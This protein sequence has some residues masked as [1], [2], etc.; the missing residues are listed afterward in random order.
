MRRHYCWKTCLLTL[1]IANQQVDVG[2]STPTSPTSDAAAS[3]NESA[4]SVKTKRRG[5]HKERRGRDNHDHNNKAVERH[6]G[7]D[8]QQ[9]E[10][11][12]QGK[13]NWK[14]WVRQLLLQEHIERFVLLDGLLTRAWR[15]NGSPNRRKSRATVLAYLEND[16]RRVVSFALEPAV[17]DK[18][19]GMM[20]PLHRDEA[21]LMNKLFEGMILQVDYNTGGDGFYQNFQEKLEIPICR[22]LET[23]SSALYAIDTYQLLEPL[24]LQLGLTSK[25][26][27]DF[28]YTPVEFSGVSRKHHYHRGYSSP[29]ALVDKRAQ[30]TGP[31]WGRPAWWKWW[32]P[33]GNRNSFWKGPDDEYKMSESAFAGGSHGEVWRGRRLCRDE[34]ARRREPFQET[35]GESQSLIF[36]RLKVEHGYRLFEAGLREVYIGKLLAEDP[37]AAGLFTTYVNHFFRE[38][39]KRS[40]TANPWTEGENDLELWIVFEDAGPS[41]R[42]YLYSPKSNGDFVVY[43]HSYLWTKLRQN[44]AAHGRKEDNSKSVAMIFDA[45]EGEEMINDSDKAKRS[46]STIN[47]KTVM[48]EVLRQVLTAAAFLHEHGIVH[49]DIKPSNL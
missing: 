15:H 42:S 25:H 16:D 41:M 2:S 13:R 5:S 17:D 24:H 36:K 49:R 26:A 22:D 1:L 45:Y 7:E 48:K 29:T 18:A 4:R 39:P 47:G 43:Q 8:Q 40:T 11:S 6:Q 32:F 44:A 14:R 37:S 27:I 21:G 28:A 38:V 9:V 10:D 35:C 30:Y 46:N 34:N 19:L 23:A 3:A 20:A 31:T 33:L 12:R